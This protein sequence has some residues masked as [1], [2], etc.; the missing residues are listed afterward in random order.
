LNNIPKNEK[1]LERLKG[2][3]E[4]HNLSKQKKGNKKLYEKL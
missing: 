2:F 4:L 1:E 3:E